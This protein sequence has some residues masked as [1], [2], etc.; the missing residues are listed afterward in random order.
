M[1]HN[2]PKG[3][4]PCYPLPCRLA[5]IALGILQSILAHTV[6][7]LFDLLH[8][9]FLPKSPLSLTLALTSTLSPASALAPPFTPTWPVSNVSIEDWDK[10]HEEML[11]CMA[12]WVD[13]FVQVN[14][15]EVLVKHNVP[16]NQAF[17]TLRTDSYS[18]LPR[19]VSQLISAD[20]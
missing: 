17:H 3:I 1:I 16:L 14:D 10:R 20:Y 18:R 15:P 11:V 5:L 4:G 7:A 2:I 13:R 19:F 12:V 9:Y 8:V 6:S